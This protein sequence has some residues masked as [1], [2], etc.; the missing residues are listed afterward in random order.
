MIASWGPRCSH[1]DHATTAPGS[2]RRFPA[3]CLV[4]VS[5]L[6]H[7]SLSSPH[8]ESPGLGGKTSVGLRGKPSWSRTDLLNVLLTGHTSFRLQGHTD[9]CLLLSPQGYSIPRGGDTCRAQTL[10]KSC[11]RLR[12]ED[13]LHQPKFQGLH[14]SA[15][16]SLHYPPSVSS[17]RDKLVFL[18]LLNDRQAVARCLYT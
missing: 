3:L 11:W 15:S 16:S 8:T 4:L 17:A 5:S 12:A 10:A 7:K 18:V 9:V 2:S 14:A 6:H 13:R 1:R